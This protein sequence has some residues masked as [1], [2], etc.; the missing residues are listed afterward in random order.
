[1]QR[2]ISRQQFQRAQRGFRGEENLEQ[3]ECGRRYGCAMSFRRGEIMQINAGESGEQFTDARIVRFA[4]E[5]GGYVSASRANRARQQ[6]TFS[7]DEGGFQS[8]SVQE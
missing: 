1:M 6:L 3:Y 2:A 4:V 7:P 5:E 8:A